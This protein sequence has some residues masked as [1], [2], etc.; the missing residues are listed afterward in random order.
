LKADGN[1]SSP[2]AAMFAAQD[3]TQRGKKMGITALYLKL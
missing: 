1:E 2:H 3:V